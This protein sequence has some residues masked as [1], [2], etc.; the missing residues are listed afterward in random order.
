MGIAFQRVVI[1]MLENS[2]RANV[3]ANP[4]M[5]ALRSKGVFLSNSYGVTHSSQPNYINAVAGDTF[6]LYNDTPGYVQWI[7]STNNDHPVT[8]IVDLLE[9]QGLSWKSYAESLPPDYLQQAQEYFPT[10]PADPDPNPG[11][12]ARKHVPFLSFPNIV[13]NDN[14]AAN[15]VDARQFKLDLAAGTLP[16]YSWYTPNLINDG[17]SLDPSESKKDP[18]DADRHTNIGNLAKF[19]QDFLGDDP[20]ARFPP[21]TLIVITFDEAYPYH[22]AYEIYSLLIGDMLPAGTVR[23]EPYNHYSLLR[24]IEDN[25]GL[26]SLKRNDAAATP[27]WFLR[28]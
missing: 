19:L 17:H 18:N 25:F 27:Y 5:N 28:R 13:Q 10:I 8:S 20:V 2:T 15:I 6:G 22:D 9:A 26:G 7:Y 21:E 12:F 1:V 4:Y 23:T 11:F 14:R 3:M 16:S 24:S